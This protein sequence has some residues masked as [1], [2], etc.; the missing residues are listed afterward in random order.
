M[1]Y[2]VQ[3]PFFE[4]IIVNGHRQSPEVTHEFSFV[5]CH[6]KMTLER[7]QKKL[8]DYEHFTVTYLCFNT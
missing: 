7:G 3:T 2:S 4:S 1:K 8:H 6:S 5:I